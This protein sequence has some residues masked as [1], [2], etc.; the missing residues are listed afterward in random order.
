MNMGD[1]AF[2]RV[3]VDEDK[4][5]GVIIGS[6]FLNWQYP[7]SPRD[8]FSRISCLYYGVYQLCAYCSRR[9]MFGKIVV[10]LVRL[11]ALA[12]FS[13]QIKICGE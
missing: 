5:L 10:L 11:E 12:V 13:S 9:S 6:N 2:P 3:L 7:S 4:I 8:D 1:Q